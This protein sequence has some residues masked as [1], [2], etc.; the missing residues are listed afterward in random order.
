MSNQFLCQP[1]EPGVGFLLARIFS[2]AKNPCQ[3]ADDIAIENWSRL[4]EGD[5]AN[6]AG[7]VTADARQGENIVVL[8]WELVGDDVRS[9]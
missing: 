7:G 4:I 1:P 2:D 9:L 3:H 8:V 6:R 5:A